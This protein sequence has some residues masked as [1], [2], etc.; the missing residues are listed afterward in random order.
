MKNQYYKVI[1]PPQNFTLFNFKEVLQFKE[2]LYALVIKDLKVMYVQTFLGY[3]WAI[4]NP[5]LTMLV[6]TIVFGGIGKIDTS[7][8]PFV[9]Y[10]LAGTC[11]WNFVSNVIN[12]SGRSIVSSS[13]LIRK[14]YFPRVILPLSKAIVG[15]VELGISLI[16]LFI[17]MLILGHP[18]SWSF[19]FFP[20]FLILLIF[21]GLGLGLLISA[22]SIMY[23]DFFYVIPFLLRLG[24]F[25]TP[26]AFPFSAIP[27]KY[28]LLVYLN[29]LAAPIEGLRWSILG[30]AAPNAYFYLSLSCCLLLFFFSLWYFN[31]MEHKFVDT[32]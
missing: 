28:R 6:L 19:L 15:L 18:L 31:R 24:M 13:E 1:R 10:A 29:P 12:V 16:C 2:V 3:G 26:V 14:V 22:L 21:S 20:L 11:G 30:G 32:I 27:E 17:L 7:P 25:I 5:L 23:R 8:I 9:L 4:I